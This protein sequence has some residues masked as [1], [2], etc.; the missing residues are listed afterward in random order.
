VQGGADTAAP[1]TTG[2][3][4]RGKRGAAPVCGA[5]QLAGPGAVG[6]QRE[7]RTVMTSVYIDPHVAAIRQG[8][9]L[10]TNGCEECLRL[11]TPWV[12][13]RLCLMCG[14]C[15]LLRLVTRCGMPER[16][17]H[18]GGP[19]RIVQ[20]MEARR[21]VA[22]VLRPLR[23]MSEGRHRPARIASAGGNSRHLRRVPATVR[24]SDC[25]PSRQAA[26]GAPSTR[27]KRLFREGERSDYFF[28]I[29]SGK[30]AVTTTDDAGNRHVIRVHG[31]GRFPRGAGRPR[32]PSRVLHRPKWWNPAKYSWY[33]PSGLRALGRPRSGAQ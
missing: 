33:R 13:L 1:L 3:Y 7:G 16:H 27:A 23:T 28:V 14:A 25:P 11:G 18:H 9:P 30:V 8:A 31:P 15:R 2:R 5:A 26:P 10:R 24:R 20:S 4:W 19:T 21:E 17:A 22:L 12:H 6:R 29:L 32:R